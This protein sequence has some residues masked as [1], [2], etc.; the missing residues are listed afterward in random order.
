[1]CSGYHTGLNRYRIFPSLEKVI[2]DGTALD[3]PLKYNKDIYLI[4]KTGVKMEYK[5]NVIYLKKGKRKTEIIN[6]MHK[7]QI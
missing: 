5:I 7:I 2:L 3:K 6:E 1:M 4:L